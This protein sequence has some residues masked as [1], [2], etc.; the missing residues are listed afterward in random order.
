MKANH[1]KRGTGNGEKKSP[2]HNSYTLVFGTPS[3]VSSM[4]TQCVVEML[5]PATLVSIELMGDG[6][7][8]AWGFCFAVTGLTFGQFYCG[9]AGR[10]LTS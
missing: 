1:Q 7:M 8:T 6:G 5:G 3:T 10:W 2:T 4:L 9:F